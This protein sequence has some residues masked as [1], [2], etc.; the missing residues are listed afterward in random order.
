LLDCLK[1]YLESYHSFVSTFPS[2]FN[3]PLIDQ[4]LKE[5]QE[6]EELYKAK[7]VS[8]E[9][10]RE[11]RL[12]EVVIK[13]LDV[14]TIITQTLKNG[15]FTNSNQTKEFYLFIGIS[16]LLDQIISENIS[17]SNSI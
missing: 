3:Q 1:K 7:L 5:F 10:S 2:Q 8:K 15:N 9:L 11:E 16:E 12:R 4:T 6:W 14:K 17:V 13:V